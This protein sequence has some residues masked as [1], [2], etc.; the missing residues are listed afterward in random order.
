MGSTVTAPL[1]Q[2]CQ[3]WYPRERIYRILSRDIQVGVEKELEKGDW[4][5]CEVIG[6][7]KQSKE[8]ALG[9]EIES[10]GRGEIN[11]ERD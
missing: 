3:E 2:V 8:G 10:L 4:R 5:R 1:I 11:V 9:S 6:G 7:Q